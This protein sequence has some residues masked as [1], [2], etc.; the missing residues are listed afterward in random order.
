MTI[1]L[2]PP[3]AAL[4]RELPCP[5]VGTYPPAA[6]LVT[7]ALARWVAGFTMDQ[8]EPTPAGAAWLADNP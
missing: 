8:L 6:R 5:C 4:L 7:L 2:T 1:K 3:Q